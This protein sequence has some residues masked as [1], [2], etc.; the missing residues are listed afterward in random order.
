MSLGGSVGGLVE[1]ASLDVDPCQIVLGGAI[2]HTTGD[3]TYSQAVTLGANTS[4]TSDSGNITFKS[5]IDGGQSL[6]ATAGQHDRGRWPHRR[7]HGARLPEF[8]WQLR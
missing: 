4:L 5:T 2:Y 6:T 1:L 7:R 3:Q 8:Q